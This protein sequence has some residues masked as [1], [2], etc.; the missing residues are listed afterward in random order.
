MD[1][2]NLCVDTNLRSEYDFIINNI[3]NSTYNMTYT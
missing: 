2:G 1:L 3:T